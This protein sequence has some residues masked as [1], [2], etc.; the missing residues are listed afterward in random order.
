MTYRGRLTG[1]LAAIAIALALTSPLH[2]QA[3]DPATGFDPGEGVTSPDEPAPDAP[4]EPFTEPASDPVEGWIELPAT[5]SEDLP[6]Q[7]RAAPASPVMRMQSRA[8]GPAIHMPVVIELYTSQG[9]SA[10][11]PAD[12]LLSGLVDRDDVLP[13]AFHVDYWDYL[14]WADMFARPE[15]TQRQKAY[16]RL[17]G[18]RSIYTP[19]MI[20]NGTDTL[21]ALRP[22]DLVQLITAHRARPAALSISAR[23]EAARYRVDLVPEA[24]LGARALVLLV[25]Y[26]PRREVTMRSGE[27]RGK[28]MEY[29]NIVTDMEAVADWDGQTPMRLT[30]SP[31]EDT[32]APSAHPADTRHAI[33]VQM[34]AG[35]GGRLPGPIIAALKLD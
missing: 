12:A 21:A 32:G 6:A 17:A 3:S 2:A 1:A 4:S 34:R 35:R 18:E 31:G 19:Q 28:T 15:F 13:L 24:D 7:D 16:A 11:P 10:C 9:C 33:L 30:V 26:L 27:N 29:H 22:A 25:R 14:G 20:V 8:I 23:N 5:S